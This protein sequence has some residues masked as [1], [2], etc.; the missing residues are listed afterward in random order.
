[1]QNSYSDPTAYLT[2]SLVG[3]GTR[4][5]LFHHATKAKK[6]ERERAAKSQFL[7]AS[8]GFRAFYM[9]T[10]RGGWTCC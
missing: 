5:I 3:G 4:V 6:K 9:S 1:M 10:L 8:P 7:R 2:W